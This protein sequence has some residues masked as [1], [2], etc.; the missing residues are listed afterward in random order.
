VLIGTVFEVDD[1]DDAIDDRGRT[2]LERCEQLDLL[3]RW[4]TS[5]WSRLGTISFIPGRDDIVRP[6]RFD[7]AALPG[8]DGTEWSGWLCSRRGYARGASRRPLRRCDAHQ[9]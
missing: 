5:Y 6:G 1:W 8:T 9:D 2:P 7:P 4:L 3:H